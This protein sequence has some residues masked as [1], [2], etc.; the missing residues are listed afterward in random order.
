MSRT[1]W[2]V[3]VAGL[4][5]YWPVTGREIELAR[6]DPD[7][8]YFTWWVPGLLTCPWSVLAEGT[9]QGAPPDVVRRAETKATVAGAILNG[10]AFAAVVRLWPRRHRPP[11][12]EARDYADGPSGVA[13]DGRTDPPAG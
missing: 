12:D 2:L 5:F 3:V 10:L 6:A 8:R 4:A 11:T 13:P 7:P 1:R 9:S